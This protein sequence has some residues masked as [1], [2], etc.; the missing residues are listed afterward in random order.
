MPRTIAV[1][2]TYKDR[3]LL[4]PKRS[5]AQVSNISEIDCTS[6]HCK[7]KRDYYVTEYVTNDVMIATDFVWPN[8]SHM[9]LI[10]WRISDIM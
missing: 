5:S 10:M 3:R 4:E 7:S 1:A 2:V 9:W 8:R 6:V